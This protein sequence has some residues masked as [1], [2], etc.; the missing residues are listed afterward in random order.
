MQIRYALAPITA[1]AL[2]AAPALAAGLNVSVEVP[3]LNVSEYHRP[4]VAAWIERADNSLAGTLAVWYDVR[5]KTNNPEGEGTKWLKDLRQWWRR[6]GRE[7]AVPVDGITG[8]TKPAGKHAVAVTEGSAAMPKLAPGAYKLVVEAARE[9]GGREV[10]S[11]PF[12]WP[13]TAA[14]QP[15][16]SGKE[17]LGAIKLELKP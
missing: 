5:T 9:V 17:E 10:V 2:F 1:S 7:L 14:A 4:Y 3:R 12:Q 8:A 6:G 13:P 16:A 11:I 15:T